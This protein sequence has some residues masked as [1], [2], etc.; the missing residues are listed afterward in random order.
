MNVD[1]FQLALIDIYVGLI[2]IYVGFNWHDL[3]LT[4]NIW[5]L[6]WMD[7]L[8][9]S[10]SYKDALTKRFTLFKGFNYFSNKKK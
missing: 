1:N 4:V 10:V 9:L 7:F 3:Y 5:K 8:A 2:Y 6:V